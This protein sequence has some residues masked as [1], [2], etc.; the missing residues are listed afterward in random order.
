[1]KPIFLIYLPCGFC[2]FRRF[3]RGALFLLFILVLPCVV[4]GELITVPG[5][6]DTIQEAVDS[7]NEGDEIVVSPG[8]YFE[9]VHFKGKNIILRSINPTSPTVVNSTVIDAMSSGSVIT[10]NGNEGPNC[11]LAGF[12]I[13]HGDAPHVGG[14]SGNGCLATI[15]HNIVK[16]N[17]AWDS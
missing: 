9:N 10:F 15:R 1:M 5:S 16:E 8:T 14:I 4:T 12:T 7:A 3:Y 17:V 6:S 11:I 13:T 2:L